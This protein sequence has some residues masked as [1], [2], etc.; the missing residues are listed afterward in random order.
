[1]NGVSAWTLL[2]AHGSACWV[3]DEDREQFDQAV[4]NDD[5]IVSYHVLVNGARITVRTVEGHAETVIM[6]EEELP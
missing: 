4:E 6:L 5:E 2:F 1:M 3:T